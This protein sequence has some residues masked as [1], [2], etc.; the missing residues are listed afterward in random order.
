VYDFSAKIICRNIS[1]IKDIENF[2]KC[3]L[4]IEI[5]L[6]S[7]FFS[8]KSNKVLESMFIIY[9]NNRL[10]FGKIGIVNVGSFKGKTD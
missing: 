1:F 2:D 8:K 10:Y 6:F 4:G 3:V 7:I 5:Y 9:I